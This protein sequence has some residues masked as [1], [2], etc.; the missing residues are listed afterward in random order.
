VAERRHGRQHT[1]LLKNIQPLA[2]WSDPQWLTRIGSKVFFI[3][4][5]GVHGRELWKTDGTTT[6]TKLV[7]DINQQP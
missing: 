6:G 4:D 2:G 3:A 7:K 1:V 5:D